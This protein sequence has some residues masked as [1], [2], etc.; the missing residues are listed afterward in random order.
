LQLG[1]KLISFLAD[2]LFEMEFLPP[3][4]AIWEK[5]KQL[6]TPIGFFSDQQFLNI[7]V[8]DGINLV[9]HCKLKSSKVCGVLLKCIATS[10]VFQKLVTKIIL[11]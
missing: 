6:R 11:I 8:G 9:I 2:A 7:F 3:I 4:K 5:R 1:E 10:H